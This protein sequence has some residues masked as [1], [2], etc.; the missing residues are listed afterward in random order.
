M[1]VN[2]IPQGFHSITPHLVCRNAKEAI[3][4]YQK[5]FGAEN[6]RS[7]ITPEGS[8]MHAELKIGDSII[9][10]GEEYPSWNV[11]SPQSLG[12]STVFIHIYT[13][14]VDALYQRAINAGCTAAMPVMDQFWGDRYGQVIDPYGHRWSLATHVEDVPEEEM[15]RRG[16]AAMEQMKKSA[17]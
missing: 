2:K 17:S 4:F 12:N 9:M 5:A 13:E 1:A 16:A 14:D 11:L 3:E 8:V 6:I 10:L 15:E 7:H